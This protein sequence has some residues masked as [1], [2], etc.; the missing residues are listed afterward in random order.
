MFESAELGRTVDKE[1][2]EARVPELR[3]ELLELQHRLKTAP[4]SVLIVVAGVEGSGKGETVNLLLEW[5]DAR[6]V[7]THALGQPTEEEREHPEYFRF[8]RHLPPLGQ[9]AIYFGSWYTSPITRAAFGKLD[10]DEL[11]LASRQI[12][13]FERML[14]A[15]NVLVVKFW[16]HLSKKQQKKRF[17]KLGDD[18]DT[19]WRVTSE[20][21]QLH[22]VYDEFERAAAR[23]IQ[24][25][26]SAFAPWNVIEAS[27][28]RHRSLAVGEKL[29]TVLAERLEA[30]V[31]APPEPAPLPVPDELS[32]IRSLDLSLQLDEDEYK[33]RRRSAQARIGRSARRLSKRKRS[34]VLVFEGNDAAG[35]GGCIRRLTSVL[36]ARHYRVWPIAAPTSEEAE[37]PY[38]WRFWRRLPR[39]GHIAVFDRSWYGRVLV[40]RIEGFAAPDAWQRAFLEINAFEEALVES[41]CLVLKF[42]LAT[43]PDEQLRR[44]KEREATGYKRHKITAEDWRNRDKWDA[45]EAAASEM[46]RR[47]DTAAAPWTLVPA[48]DKRYARVQVLETIADRLEKA[49]RKDS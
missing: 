8:W 28:R 1:A 44:F 30:P 10:D 6:G 25:T 40:E 9:T 29:A 7:A 3:E 12:V 16:L 35:K 2:F 22:E 37:R 17:D 27:D 43:S 39:W 33:D 48:E 20:D 24:H 36:D 15:E 47:T 49:V 19:A 31:T 41:D 26:D 45:Y 18:E 4:F 13:D 46:L 5:L 42:W 38:L 23:S 14:A 34:A 32:P 11:E 21:W